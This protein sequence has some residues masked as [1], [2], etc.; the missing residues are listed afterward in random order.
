M[1]KR[2]VRIREVRREEIDLQLLAHALLR[3]ARERLNEADTT[4]EK[5]KAP[6]HDDD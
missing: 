3:L 1:T 6:E 4:A 5:P 2:Y